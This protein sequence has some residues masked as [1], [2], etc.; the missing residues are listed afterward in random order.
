MH[1]LIIDIFAFQLLVYAPNFRKMVSCNINLKE[2][3]CVNTNDSNVVAVRY[4]GRALIALILGMVVCFL[5][6]LGYNTY[7]KYS[8]KKIE[9][10]AENSNSTYLNTLE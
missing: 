8:D 1:R 4:L 2:V 3:N 9:V 6:S 10:Q 7:I 5:A